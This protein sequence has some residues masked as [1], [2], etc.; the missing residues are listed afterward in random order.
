MGDQI[1]REQRRMG[2]LAAAECEQLPGK[3]RRLFGRV[4]N[5]QS[6]GPRARVG[7]QAVQQHFVISADDR[8]QIVKIM[9]DA[10]GKPPHGVHLL[11]LP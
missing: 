6:V 8:Q 1:G 10:A 11:G 2:R 7:C 4:K 3:R 5:F 9:R